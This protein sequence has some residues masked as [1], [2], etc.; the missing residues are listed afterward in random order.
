M[1]KGRPLIG[2]KPLT[3]A[4][5]QQRHREKKANAITK[6]KHQLK[7][8]SFMKQSHKLR[9]ALIELAETLE[10]IK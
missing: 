9:A 1:K 7:Q 4:E 8:I 2:D 10:Q 5:K 3:N 6:A